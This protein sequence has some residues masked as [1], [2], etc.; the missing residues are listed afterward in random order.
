MPT[1]WRPRSTASSRRLSPDRPVWRRN[2][3]IHD[4]PSFFLPEP[5]P[6][7]EATPPEGRWLRSERQTLRRLQTPGTVLFTI[8]TQQLPLAAVA[9]RPDVAARMARAILGWS[10]ELMAYKGGHG[11]LASVAWL[12]SL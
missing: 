11:A 9:K 5:T 2:W 1:S 6:A 3:S 7:T 8:R 10:P 4:D 12:Q